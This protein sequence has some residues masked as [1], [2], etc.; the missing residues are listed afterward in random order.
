MAR[1]RRQVSDEDKFLDKASKKKF[2]IIAERGVIAE[3]VIDEV[4][5]EKYGLIELLEER[6]LYKSGIFAESY[7]L[8][9][10]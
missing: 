8:S 3:R 7:S 1:R 9:L 2:K 4:A 6:C 5:I 10:V